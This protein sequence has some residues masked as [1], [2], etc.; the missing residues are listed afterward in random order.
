MIRLCAAFIALI[1]A[2]ATTPTLAINSVYVSRVAG[3]DSG[4]GGGEFNLN[5][6]DG[7]EWVLDNYV[8]GKTSFGSGDAE[9]FQSFCLEKQEFISLDRSF[10]VE[11]NSS[12]VPGGLGA[13]AGKDPLSHGTAWLYSQFARGVL[14]GYDYTPGAGRATS[15]ANLQNAIWYLEHENASLNPANPFA[16]ALTGKFGS[17]AAARTDA[18]PFSYGVGVLNLSREVNGQRFTKQDQL[19]LLHV[20]EAGAT[21]LLLGSSVLGL[22]ALRRRWA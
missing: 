17:L 12:S 14:L 10:D 15:A 21:L 9:G 6:T 5:P 19:V 11:I 2:L 3:T 18:A 16:I 4:T 1:G 13:I 22:G 7:L 20:P 8:P